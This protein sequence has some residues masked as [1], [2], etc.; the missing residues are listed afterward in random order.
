MKLRIKGMIIKHGFIV[1]VA[2][3]FYDQKIIKT[4]VILIPILG[5]PI[6]PRSTTRFSPLINYF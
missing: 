2:L 6:L 4:G 3:F 5:M 1:L